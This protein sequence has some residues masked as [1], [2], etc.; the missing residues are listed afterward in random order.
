MDS[1][2]EN[3]GMAIFE[4]LILS[5]I[6]GVLFL[7][8]NFIWNVPLDDLSWYETLIRVFPWLETA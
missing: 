6:A 1:F 4:L 2:F 3:F 5:A 8:L 7:V